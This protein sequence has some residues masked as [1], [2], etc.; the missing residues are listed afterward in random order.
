MSSCESSPRY[1]AYVRRKVLTNVLPG[2]SENSS[3][4]SARRYFARILVAD[5]TSAMSIFWRMRASRRRSPIATAPILADGRSAVGRGADGL[6]ER[7]QHARQI[8]LGDQYLA[9]LRALVAR[10]H[11]APLHHV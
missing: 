10:Y 9:G 8:R 11:A 6:V 4:S 2:S 5:S 1:S 7:R 3:F